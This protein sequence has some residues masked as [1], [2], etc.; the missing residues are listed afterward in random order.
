M[1][2]RSS[3]TPLLSAAALLVGGT[4]GSGLLFSIAEDV[5]YIEGLWLAFTIVSTTGFGPGPAT[6]TGKI[7]AMVLFAVTVVAYVL[8]LIAAAES[9]MRRAQTA[10]PH[11]GRQVIPEADIA[12]IMREMS[13]N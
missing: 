4:S 3:R 1:R 10:H 8:L 11:R 9:A 12:R 13:Q 2:M 5:S 6:A 7:L